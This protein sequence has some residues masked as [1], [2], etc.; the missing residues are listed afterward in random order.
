WQRMRDV[1]SGSF[2][3]KRKAFDTIRNVK[4]YHAGTI[5]FE[6][7]LAKRGFRL[8]NIKVSYMP[9]VG[10]KSKLAKYK[11]VY[12]FQV[13]MGILKSRFGETSELIADM[14]KSRFGNG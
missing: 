9:R 3:I 8:K 14:L 4:T 10:T 11:V 7:E 12:G 5:F 6:M 2:A 13:F 1:F